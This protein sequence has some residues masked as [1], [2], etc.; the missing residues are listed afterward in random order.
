LFYAPNINSYKRYVPGSFAPTSVRWGVD[1]RSCAIRLV[2]H[3]HSLRP[4]NRTPGGDVNPYLAIA[5]M[6]AAGL[7]GIDNKLPL[8]PAFEG[9]AYTDTSRRVPSTMR[10]AMELFQH[11]EIA[12]AAFGDAVIEHYVNYAR[13]ELAAYDAA[14]TDW[15]LRRCFERL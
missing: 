14:V 9:S 11:S 10:D 5:G 15:E 6:I 13:V 8:E 12:R 3:G 7:H 2:G 4:E 1:N